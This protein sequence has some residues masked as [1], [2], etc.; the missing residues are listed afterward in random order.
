MKLCGQSQQRELTVRHAKE[1]EKEM[2]KRLDVQK[3]EYEETVKRH[4]AFIDQ[5]HTR[6]TMRF[7]LLNECYVTCILLLLRWRR[8]VAVT[9]LGVSAKLLYVGP[10]FF[11]GMG[12]H[13]SI[14]PSHPGQLS[15]LPSAG[16]EMSTSQSA[17]ML[18]GWGVKAGMVHSTCG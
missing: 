2:Q 3:V 4:I 6:I 8:G 11:A 16:R 14:S 13:L 7:V 12:D 17:V 10:G 9:S 1:T 18:C 15:L 5:V